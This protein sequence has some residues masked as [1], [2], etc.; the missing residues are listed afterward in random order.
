VLP[1]ADMNVT[2]PTPAL[3]EAIGMHQI[4]DRK[5]IDIAQ[6]NS[7]LLDVNPTEPA[8]A[9]ARHLPSPEPT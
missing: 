9:L 2:T 5:E 6:T 4:G 3:N 8:D 7:L 1:D